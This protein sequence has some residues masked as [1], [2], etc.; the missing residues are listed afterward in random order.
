MK[1]LLVIALIAV[2][3]IVALF[4]SERQK[5]G[6]QVSPQAILDW[7]AGIQRQTTRVPAAATRLS[8]S[9]EI[10]IGDFLAIH[11]SIMLNQGGTRADKDAPRIAAYVNS[12]GQRLAAHAH[13][14]LPYRFHY[15]SNPK[16]VNA[17]ALPGGHVFIGKGLILRMHTED[18]LASVLGHEIEHIDHFHC[19]ERYQV[20]ARLRH[21]PF[22]QLVMLPIDVFQAGYTKLQEMEA[23]REG[24]RL[25]VW[26]GYS[27]FGAL[28]MF[29][30]FNKASRRAKKP[31]KTPQ[32]EASRLVLQTLGGYFR[33]HPP[34]P[35][36]IAQIRRLIADE[37][38]ETLTRE[39]RLK[40]WPLLHPGKVNPFIHPF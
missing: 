5:V 31:A 1:R 19:V 22:G 40:V 16:F 17:F 24:T 35:Q 10:E 12:V 4:L 38:W 25:A 27:P 9:Q 37:H 15:V 23:D 6:T 21:V 33:A 32:E 13:R 30:D 11:Y 18:E 3:G 2:L 39:R 36:R 34:M 8:R 14:K 28:R 20:A 7:I 29:E 26:A